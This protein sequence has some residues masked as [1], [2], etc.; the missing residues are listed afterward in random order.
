M[1]ADLVSEMDHRV[2]NPLGGEQNQSEDGQGDLERLGAQLGGGDRLLAPARGGIF[3]ECADSPY[4][5]EIDER[6]GEGEQHHGDA[7]S[8]LVKAFGRSVDS[9][10]GSEG[11]EANGYTDAADGDDSGASTL[12]KGEK[13]TRPVKKLDARRQRVVRR[14]GNSFVLGRRGAKR[15]RISH[16][17]SVAERRR[18]IQ[19]LLMAVNGVTL[20]FWLCP[21]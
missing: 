9:R 1:R 10:S 21:V 19:R 8:V 13:N 5:K 4:D 17:R 6:S 15:G 11:T 3:S 12:Q 16:I 14:R 7:D 18:A 2:R 20:A